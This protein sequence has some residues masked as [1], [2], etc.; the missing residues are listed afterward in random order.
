MSDPRIEAAVRALR[1]DRG[2]AL[3]LQGWTITAVR[4]LA[5]RLVDA[6]DRASPHSRCYWCADTGTL[7]DGSPCPNHCAS[8]QTDTD[9]VG[10]GEPSACDGECKV[11]GCADRAMHHVC[12]SCRRRAEQVL[13]RATP[14]PE[15]TDG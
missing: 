4:E 8:R 6:V 7:G 13:A 11:C 2:M 14:V 3:L 1:A 10:G 5:T 15:D 9:A 12:E